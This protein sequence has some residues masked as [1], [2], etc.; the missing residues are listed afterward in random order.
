MKPQT[1]AWCGLIFALLVTIITIILL[2][3]LSVIPGVY[4]ACCVFALCTNKAKKTSKSASA[5][6]YASSFSHDG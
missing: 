6:A 1:L 4:A 5:P 2:P 3:Q